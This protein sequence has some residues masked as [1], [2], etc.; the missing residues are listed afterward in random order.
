MKVGHKGELKKVNKLKK[1]SAI[2][3]VF[4]MILQVLGSIPFNVL[5]QGSTEDDISVDAIALTDTVLETGDQSHLSVD[6]QKAAE[7]EQTVHIQLPEALET[8]SVSSKLEDTTGSVVGNVTV[9]SSREVQ[10]NVTANEA[11]NG[12]YSL[13][14]TV[15]SEQ[16][17]EQTW[18]VTANGTDYAVQVVMANA[19]EAAETSES[20][21]EEETQDDDDEDPAPTED[22]EENVDNDMEAEGQVDSEEDANSEEADVVEEA[23]VQ[24]DSIGPQAEL[25]NIFEFDWFRLNGEDIEDGAEVDFDGT[26]D[27]QFS[28]E[29]DGNTQAGDTASMPLPD[30]FQHWVDT[31]DQ[32]ITVEGTP[33][34][35]FTVNNGELVFTFNE[36]IGDQSV[37]NGYVGFQLNFEREKFTEEWEQEIDFDGDGERDLTVQVIPT[38]V[39]TDLDK[40]GRTDSA[41]NA[42]EVYWTVDIVNGANEAIENGTLADVIPEGL[43]EARDFVVREIT[44]DV[45]GN[46]I[47]GDEVDFNTPTLTDDGFEITI[48]SIEG[49]SGYRIEYTTSIDDY[50]IS[51][52]T[53]DATFVYDDGEL[54]AQSTVDGGER[55][56][57]IQKSGSENWWSEDHPYLHIDWSIVVNENGM[58]IDDA[59]VHD[60]L[61]EYLNVDEDSIVISNNSE[62]VTDQFEFDG[63][64][65]ELGEVGQDETYTIDFVTTIDWDIYNDGEFQFENDFENTAELTDGEDSLGEDTA[66]LTIWREALVQKSGNADDYSYENNILSWNI[67]VNEA[68][69]PIDDAVL[70]DTLP[71]GLNISAED[72][73]IE[74]ADVDPGSIEI[75]ENEDGT[76]TVRI[77]LGSIDSEVTISYT[78]EVADFA[79]DGFTNTAQLEGDGVGVDNPQDDGEANPPANDFQKNF[80]GIDYN[81]KTIDWELVVNPHR[82]PIDSLKITDSFPNGGL[83]VLEDT[84]EVTLDGE[85]FSDYDLELTDEGHSGF[86]ITINDDVNIDGRLVVNFATSYDTEIVENPHNNEDESNV[87]RNSAKYEG[88]T[89]NGNDF[90][91]PRE[92]DTRVEDSAWNSGFKE[93]NLIAEEDWTNASDR[94]IAWQVYFNYNQHDLGSGVFVT[95]T[96][97]YEGEIIEDSITVSVY[98]VAANGE[99]TIT[100]EVLTLDEDYTVDVNNEDGELTVNFLIDV[101]ERYVIEFDTTVPDISEENYVNNAVVETDNGEFPY[102]SSVDYDRWD[103][104][105]DKEVLPDVREVYIGEELEWKIT[106]NESLSRIRNATLTD[107]ISPGLSFVEDSF[108]IV[109]GSGEELIEGRDYTLESE[110]T[111]AGETEL[112]I[113]FDE[114]LTEAVTIT[115]TTIVTAEDGEP[116]NNTVDLNGNGIETETRQ[117]EEITATQFSWVGGEFREDRGAIKINKV[118]SATEGVIDSSEAT[119]ELYRVVNDERV[120]MGEYT[121]ENGILE[122]GNLHLGTYI[123][124]ETEAPDGY[125][126]SGE[127]MEIEV[128][129]VYGNDEIVSEENFSNISDASIDIPVLKVWEDAADQDGARPESIEVELLANGEAADVDNLTLNAENDW[130]DT[131]VGLPVLDEAGEAIEYAIVEV[132]VEV[133]YTSVITGDAEDGFMITNSRAVELT[134]ISGAKTWDDADNQDGV[135]PESITVNLLANGEEVDEQVVTVEDDWSYTFTGLPKFE[136]GEEITYTV[137]EDAVEDYTPTIDGYDITNSYTPDVTSVTVTKAWEDANNQDGLRSEGVRV[138]L[139]ANGEEAGDPIT[140]SNENE[141]TH[142]WTE[143]AV[144]E[145]GE[146]ITYTVEELNVHE[147]YEVD[148]N[149]EDLGNVTITNS[150]IP[151]VTEVSGTKTW[152]DADNQDRVRPEFITVNLLADG[153][154]VD[155]QIVTAADNWSYT[156][157]NLPVNQPGE[158][159][160]EIAYT[161]EEEAVEG[162]EVSYDGYD[163]TNSYTPEV[164]EISGEKTWD[165][166]DDQDGVRPDEV[167]INLLANGFEVAEQVVTA[168]ENWSYTFESLPRFEDGEEINYTVT[169]DSV[170]GYTTTVDGYDITNTRTPDERS[171]TVTKAWD[172][173]NNQDGKRS[174]SVDVQLFANGE[175]Y[176]EPITLSDENEWTHTWTELAVNESGEEVTYTVEELNVHDDYEVAIDDENLGNVIIINSYDP[177]YID[178]EGTKTWD[179][180]DNQDGLRPEFITIRLY[181]GSEEVDTVDVTAEEDWTFEFTDLPRFANG[182]EINYTVQEDDVEEYSTEID[183]MDIVNS[184]TPGQTSVNV[185]KAWDDVQNQDGIRPDSITVQL[186]AD[187]EATGQELILSAENNWQ[188]DFTELDT[189]QNGEQI[190]YTIKEV[191]VEGY[192]EAI[193]GTSE[194]G[195]VLTN[196]YESEDPEDPTDPEGSGKEDPK[197]PGEPEEEDPEDGEDSEGESGRLPQTN[198]SN[199]SQFYIIGGILLLALG[200]TIIVIEKKKKA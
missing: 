179:D 173:A 22:V 2:I 36:N 6:W 92:D 135:R 132:D 126:L 40:S 45:D 56:N 112:N 155:E 123:V 33:V 165:D 129:E 47:V 7:E 172:D 89:V 107:T 101:T 81:A 72:I 197:D 58:N 75:T 90:D 115:Y 174:E 13:P 84:L 104:L 78:T 74:G 60:D 161:V 175:E 110:P 61:P 136:A 85:L 10:L 121:T 55:S 152:D 48:D 39:N 109:T 156:F 70:V 162:Y 53:N 8:T 105:L 98:D 113:S 26:Y 87:Y 134:D 149:D 35:T 59:I 194:D 116:V 117:T 153:E 18:N 192:E 186:L 11:V 170:E 164:T 41:V 180:T 118:D 73:N 43:G 50:S 99:T 159:G 71:E 166:A 130:Q 163:I 106:A 111:E 68:N 9:A 122:I 114:D 42:R 187:G 79:A 181:A 133:G 94:G 83:F 66:N 188:G 108:T 195:F 119:F 49:R 57:P 86:E 23:V 96:L 198:E 184:Y 32:T 125:R 12:T 21:D 65:I 131:F 3:V 150:Y 120:L 17:G 138:Q 140:L 25:G 91:V 27:I 15:Q 63:F 147:E 62:D 191:A 95:D 139:Y 154:E 143:L 178:L 100:D 76:Q 20:N 167:T 52:F 102:S 182:E 169:E 103:D 67:T 44:F 183:G 34:G 190:E 28:W 16:T 200:T 24:R 176:G 141:W 93:G 193:T 30:V 128:D 137:T 199:R 77:P 37:Q 171:V 4:A 14:V 88:E 142:T 157:D 145:A 38:E 189:H 158:V 177:E 146:G 160:Q 69:H 97:D 82:E 1:L 54:E 80:D 185:V 19:R 46:E 51:Q 196:S 144:N 148:I 127:E 5:A 29:T 64:P 168:E 151:E 124:V 31:P